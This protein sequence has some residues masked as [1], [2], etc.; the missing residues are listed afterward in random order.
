MLICKNH[1]RHIVTRDIR[2][3]YRRW[4]S[5]LKPSSWC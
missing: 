5:H 2:I 1:K 4:I 3:S